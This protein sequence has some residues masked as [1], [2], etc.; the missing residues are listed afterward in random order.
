MDT[1]GFSKM[2]NAGIAFNKLGPKVLHITDCMNAGT[3]EAIIS[4]VKEHP[5]ASHYILW[6][7]RGDAPGPTESDLN[8]Y[9]L[10]NL[11]WNSR[12]ISSKA[13]VMNKYVRDVSPNIV[14]LHSSRAGF[15]GRLLIWNRVLLYTSHGF[16]FQRNDVSKQLKLFFYGLEKILSKLDFK[17]VALWPIEYQIASKNLRISNAVFHPLPI[18]AKFQGDCHLT[19]ISSSQEK[20]LLIVGRISAAK[21]PEFAIEVAKILHDQAIIR[22]IWVGTSDIANL[23]FEHQFEL[24]GIELAGWLEPKELE[25]LYSKA[26]ALLITSSWE[27]GPLVFYEAL[28][29]G[30]PCVVRSIPAFACFEIEKF[31]TFLGFAD[32]ARQLIESAEVRERIFKNQSQAIRKYLKSSKIEESIYIYG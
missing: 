20:Y 24:V 17:Y 22:I 1:S 16:G 5:S 3:K 4:L 12:S 15:F 30:I 13:R 31:E 21:D 26:S 9:F 23:H 18:L 19:K 32:Q 8:N 11:N 29:A 6:E 25:K 7:S 27:A 10:G 2:K 14:H 28:A